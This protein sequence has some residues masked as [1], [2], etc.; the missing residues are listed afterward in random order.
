MS[1]GR[2][3]P[4]HGGSG[5]P[6]WLVFLVGIAVVFGLYYVWLGIQNFVRTGGGGV[7]EATERAQIIF[8]ATAQF[9]PSTRVIA[10]PTPIPD[11]EDFTVTAPSANVRK[12]PSETAAV[13]K[14]FK[15]GEIVCVIGRPTPDS[16]WYT[17]DLQ[18]QS[19]RLEL[20]YMHESVIQAV[21]PTP[22]AS[23]TATPLPTV[24]AT[25]SPTK[26]E[27]PVPIPTDTRDPNI[28][29]TPSPTVTPSL[30]PPRQSA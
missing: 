30:T 27:T 7:L 18:P 2:R 13:L 21:H 10:T 24:T 15:Q 28:T 23:R 25:P 5:P 9:F 3:T 16:E 29:Y 4:Q 20:A 1:F 22:T 26:T 6:T 14:V 19:R 17:I 8:T 11:C 12:E